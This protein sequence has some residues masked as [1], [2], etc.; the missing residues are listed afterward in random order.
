MLQENTCKSEVE[1][2]TVVE[3]TSKMKGTT[4]V[5]TDRRKW[6]A[7]ALLC[8]VQFMVVLDI[9]IVNVALPSIQI[10]LGFSQG[11]LQWVISAYALVFGGF[12]LLGGRAA[13]M[14]G[15][16]SGLPRGDRPVH[17]GVA[18]RR[19]RLVGELAHRGPGP[20]GTRRGDHHARCSLDPVDHVPRRAGAQHRARRLGC[21]RRLR[22][23]GRRPARGSPDRRPQLGVDLLRQHPGRRAGLRPGAGA[24]GR[25]PGRPGQAVRRARSDPRDRRALR[26]GPRDHPG[27]PARLAVGR[28]RDDLRAVGRRC[29]RASSP[30]S[31]GT[32]SR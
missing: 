3:P 8:V 31:C 19:A 21:R 25:E 13:D 1:A 16:A 10:D 9:A 32:P 4:M 18:A 29:S 17:R 23:G 28:G 22:S 15:Q 30:G 27:G 12:L 14:L 7:L 24:P 20:A 2:A 6:L 26:R 5:Y 11:N